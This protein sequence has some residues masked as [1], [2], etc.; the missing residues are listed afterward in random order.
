M[1]KI[2]RRLLIFIA[3]LAQS[4]AIVLQGPSKI[5]GLPDWVALTCTGLG[6]SMSALAFIFIPI[7]PEALE[8]V[9]IKHGF[10][11]GKNEALDQALSAYASGLYGTF[12]SIGAILA[13]IIGSVI[14][15]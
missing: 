10:I 9:Y 3:F 8:G 5:L 6:L 1:G 12:Y 11:E 14:Y 7:V 2:P 4:S 15:E 13:P